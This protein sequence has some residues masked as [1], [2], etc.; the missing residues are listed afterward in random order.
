MIPRKKER[1]ILTRFFVGT[2][3]HLFG[4]TRWAARASAT[5]T[6]VH[7]AC[8][9]SF[10][11]GTHARPKQNVHKKNVLRLLEKGV[12]ASTMIARTSNMIA[13]TSALI[14]CTSA[15]IACTSAMIVRTCFNHP[16]GFVNST[17]SRVRW[18][19]DAKS[20]PHHIS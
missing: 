2:C 10:I 7:E 15:M 4:S 18:I 1:K 16:C 12:G 9:A 14:A 20:T 5:Q 13:C 8:D 19:T 3:S 11:V 6:N 17:T